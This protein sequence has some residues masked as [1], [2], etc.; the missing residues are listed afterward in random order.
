MCRV[1]RV[2]PSGYYAWLLQPESSRA[3][4]D[5]RLLG[6][7]KQSRLETGC[8]FGYRKIH[9]DLRE[10]G[11][12]CGKGRVERL[13]HQ[14]GIKAQVGYKKHKGIKGGPPSVIAPNHLQRQFSVEQPDEAWVTDITYSAPILRRYH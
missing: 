3:V 9:D 10:L 5:R 11:E 8:V 14:N 4:E 1:L 2:H 12:T 6:L 13:T 7:I